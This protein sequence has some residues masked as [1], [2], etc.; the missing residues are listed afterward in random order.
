[1]SGEGKISYDLDI[2]KDSGIT[3]DR[4]ERSYGRWQCKVPWGR[5]VDTRRGENRCYD[6]SEKVERG[7][8]RVHE[9]K[10][11]V[12]DGYFIGFSPDVEVTATPG[13]GQAKWKAKFTVYY[14]DP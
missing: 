12:E 11:L 7:I 14:K 9:I 4:S 13:S 6:I 1:M 2:A 10:E 5:V 8:V 3:H